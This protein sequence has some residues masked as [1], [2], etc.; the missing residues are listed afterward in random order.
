MYCGG[1]ARASILRYSTSMQRRFA[2]AGTRPTRDDAAAQ[3]KEF[4]YLPVFSK[5]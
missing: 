5:L 1:R 3:A 2:I 4:A